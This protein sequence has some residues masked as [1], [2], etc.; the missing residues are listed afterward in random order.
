MGVPHAPTEEERQFLTS[1]D[2][3]IVELSTLAEH[4]IGS[5]ILNG[6]RA[7]DLALK[8]AAHPGVPTGAA[9]VWLDKLGSRQ[10]SERREAGDAILRAYPN[11]NAEQ[12]LEREI[13]A[14]LRVKVCRLTDIQDTLALLRDRFAPA[15]IF[16]C[17]FHY[18]YMS[19]ARAIDWPPELNQHV[20]MA[21]RKLGIGVFN[22]AVLV[23]R[24][25]NETALDQ[26]QRHWARS[27]NPVVGGE[28]LE[29]IQVQ[30]RR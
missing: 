1:L 7:S 27:F 2:C 5:T 25:G 14:N 21:A 17:L 13:V 22:P 23:K 30:L 20:T 4:Y 6:N 16:V 18:C 3:V 11:D 26:D 8:I 19:G 29:F 15:R 10:P 28:L 12:A 24:Y 9:H